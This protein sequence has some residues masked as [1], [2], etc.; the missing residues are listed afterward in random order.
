MYGKEK[1]RRTDDGCKKARCQKQRRK[2][3][4]Q[5]SPGRQ[6]NHADLRLSSDGIFGRHN[7]PVFREESA[8]GIAWEVL[9]HRRIG[10]I[11]CRR[12]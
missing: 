7:A 1:Q 2:R 3:D 9:S 8:M 5:K 12:Q 6:E 4:G 10:V 11:S